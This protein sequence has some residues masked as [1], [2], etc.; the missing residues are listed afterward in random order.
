MNKLKKLSKGK[1]NDFGKY[2]NGDFSS[3]YES[4]F[5]FDSGLSK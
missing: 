4:Y 1:S 5:D 2:Q 3:P